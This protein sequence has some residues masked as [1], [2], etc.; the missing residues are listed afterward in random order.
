MKKVITYGTYDLFHHGHRRLLERAKEL[1]DYLIVGVTTEN[2]D[3]NRGKINAEQSLMERVKAVRDSGIADEIIVEEYEGQKIDDIKRY[4]I[5]IFTVGSDWIGKFDY[6]KKYC[7]VIYLDRTKNV[8]SSKIRSKEPVK[9]GIYGDIYISKKFYNESEHVNGLITTS[10]CSKNKKLYENEDLF[11]TDDYETFLKTNINAVFIIT[12]P[13]NHYEDIKTALNHNKHVLCESPITLNPSQYEEL[14]QIAKEKGLILMDSIKTAYSTA[15]NRLMVL[16]ESKRIGEV[17]SIDATCTSLEDYVPGKIKDYTWNSITAWGPT[18][19]L[20]IFQILG[21]NYKDINI[22][23]MFLEK[24]F[25]TFTKIDLTYEN[26]VASIK[27]GNGVKSEGELIISGTKGYAYIPAPWWKM[28]YFELRYE[29]LEDNKKHFYQLDGEGIRYMLLVF[30]KSIEI[31]K[32]YD[33]I[34]FEESK[35]IC[36]IMKEFYNENINKLRC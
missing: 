23:S 13:K 12:H 14:N 34:T 19:L 10:I 2:F 32:K 24:D 4:D 25:D 33:N 16:I 15:Y 22:N 26:A 17:L 8:S 18:A 3:R 7:D 30:A 9:L 20:P 1:G 27:V 31:A 11:I 21:T 28:D 29:N 35:A 6:L 5:D 36:N